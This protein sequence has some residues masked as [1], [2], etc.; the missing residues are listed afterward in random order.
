MNV[1][2]LSDGRGSAVDWWF[3][4]KLPRG[5]GPGKH[6]TG[7]EFLYC[8]SGWN[9]EL[10][11]SKNKLDENK[12]AIA[13]TLRQ[14]FTRDTNTGYILWNDEIPPTRSQPKPANNQAKG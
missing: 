10:H 3:V 2:A 14:L 11:L 13:Q 12:N 4:Y 8:D 1:S 6:T 9:P 5:V 7:D